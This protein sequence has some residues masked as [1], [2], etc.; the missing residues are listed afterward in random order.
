MSDG[1][2]W[3]SEFIEPQTIRENE[4]RGSRPGM[5]PNPRGSMI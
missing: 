2:T 5:L 4:M 1:Q 3:A